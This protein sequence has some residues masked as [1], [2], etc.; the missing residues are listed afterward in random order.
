MGSTVTNFPSWP[1]PPVNPINSLLPPN[2]ASG[3]NYSTGDMVYWDAGVPAFKP[4]S[5]LADLG[6]AALMQAKF[7]PLFL[8]IF[9]GQRPYTDYTTALTYP[10]YQP[11]SIIVD[12]EFDYAVVSG[13]YNPG[14]LF[15]PNYASSA[16]KDQQLVKVATPNLAVARCVGYYPNATTSIRV[17]FFSRLL[18]CV[19]DPLAGFGNLLDNGSS[20]STVAGTTTLTVGSNPIQITTATL[21]GAQNL[22]L[23]AEAESAGLMFIVVNNAADAN[24]WVVKASNGTTTVVTV[25]QNK[26]ATVWCDG[27]T[28]YGMLG[29]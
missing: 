10:V 3:Y 7:A 9:N 28:W 1:S 2:V 13:T 11:N 25:A 29:A 6:T 12:Q 24:N 21:G 18:G 14:D 5:Q 16:L 19:Y 27:T 23:P 20:S 17:R 15:G 26:R 4:A 8:G 22:V